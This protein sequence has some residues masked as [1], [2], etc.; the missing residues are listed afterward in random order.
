M[1]VRDGLVVAGVVIAGIVLAAV[2]NG[3][4]ARGCVDQPG[5]WHFMT[6]ACEGGS[7]WWTD[8]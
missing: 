5:R 2:F 1:R 6:V 7:V 4:N 3:L 8:H